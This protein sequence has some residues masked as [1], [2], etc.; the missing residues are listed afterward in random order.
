MCFYNCTQWAV[1][2]TDPRNANEVCK[3]RNLSQFV[4]CVKC[5]TKRRRFT[6]TPKFTQLSKFSYT[7][8]VYP[9]RKIQHRSIL[10]LPTRQINSGKYQES[11]CGF[12]PCNRITS[13]NKNSQHSSQQRLQINICT[14]NGRRK[15]I[16]R[17]SIK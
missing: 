12:F 13:E 1:G 15:F 7:F 14:Y 4:C 3:Q 2:L 8:H 9:T 10:L 6:A 17:Y 16:Q 11:R 5:R